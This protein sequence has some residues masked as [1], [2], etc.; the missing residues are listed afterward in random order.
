[1]AWRLEL[2]AASEVDRERRAQLLAL[3]A[4]VR[5]VLDALGIPVDVAALLADFGVLEP[6]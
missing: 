4:E 1:M 3:A 6:E 2:L 5:E